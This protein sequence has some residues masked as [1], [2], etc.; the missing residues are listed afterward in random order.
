M[1]LSGIVKNFTFFF[2]F[3][4]FY[5]PLVQSQYHEIGISAGALNYKG[6][7][8]PEFTPLNY[9]PAVNA[10]YR[11]NFNPDVALRAGLLFGQIAGNDKNWNLP[12]NQLRGAQFSSILAERKYIFPYLFSPEDVII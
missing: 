2:V 9:R 1:I 6:E 4:L 8:S 11:Y 5:C 3:Y 10:F 12:L 7:L